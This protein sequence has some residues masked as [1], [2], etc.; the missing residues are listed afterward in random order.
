MS[1][2]PGF[3]PPPPWEGPPIPGARW[4]AA[5]PGGPSEA[6]ETIT[7]TAGSELEAKGYPPG[8]VQKALVWARNS[9]E[10]MTRPIPD[11]AVRETVVMSLYPRYVEM[12][13]NW[14]KNIQ[15]AMNDEGKEVI[16]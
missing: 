3:L 7:A 8:L 10:G 6:L 16:K 15:A 14:M 2:G 9:I 12:S 13:E 4:P 1:P 5:N 11:P